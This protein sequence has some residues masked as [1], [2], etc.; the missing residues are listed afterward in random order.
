VDGLATWQKK[1]PIALRIQGSHFFQVHNR[2]ALHMFKFYSMGPLF[3]DTS[4]Y[5]L[6][7][8]PEGQNVATSHVFWIQFQIRI[9]NC[10]I[11]EHK[12]SWWIL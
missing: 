1:E 9:F 10:I 6:I 5:T 12:Y 2:R 11:L 4:Y 8:S 7:I 3:G